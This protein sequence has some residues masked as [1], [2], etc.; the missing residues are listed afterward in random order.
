[1]LGSGCS[2]LV[3]LGKVSRV[4]CNVTA[5][6]LVRYLGIFVCKSEHLIG[7]HTF[8]TKANRKAK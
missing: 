8:M 4:S 2:S 3:T 5:Q 7:S 6:R 1:M